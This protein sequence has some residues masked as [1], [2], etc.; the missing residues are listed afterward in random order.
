MYS[1]QDLMARIREGDAHAF[2]SLYERYAGMIQRHL[3]H[4]VHDAAVAQDL[5]Q[6]VFLRVWTRGEQWRGSGPFKAWLYRIASNLAL[7]HLRQVRRRKE[8]PLVVAEASMEEDEGDYVPAW[9]VDA[10][11]LGPEWIAEMTEQRAMFQELVESLPEEKQAVF[12]LVHSLEM[13]IQDAA[14]ELGIPEGTVKS[15]LHYAK[16][17]LAQEW[18]DLER[19]WE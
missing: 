11:A 17:H 12:R 16:K 3:T 15:R 8:Q 1:D 14:D 13:S 7:N 2:E 6:E 9:M 19:E 4:I 18:Q 5:L 10:S